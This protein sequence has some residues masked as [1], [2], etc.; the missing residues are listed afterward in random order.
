MKD[1]MVNRGPIAG[2]QG[3]YDKA[4]QEFAEADPMK[5][6]ANSGIPY[7]AGASAFLADSLGERIRITHPDGQVSM[8]GSD[9]KPL[10][11]W[12]FILMHHLVRADGA[13]LGRGMIGYRETSSGA[14]YF[15]SHQDKTIRP[16]ELF[17]ADKPASRI[18]EACKA[19]GA[20]ACA[21]SSADVCATFQFAPR[22]PITFQLW[23]PDEEFGCQ[24]NLLYDASAN[25]YLHTEDIAVASG[26]LSRFLM[27]Q[28]KGMFL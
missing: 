5:Q 3:S 23:L 10:W 7:D 14:F 21:D 8:D 19:L 18:L 20:E 13:T 4:L 22:F 9:A 26:I 11:T 27:A 17:F 24:V 25:H 28:Y 2:Y 1:Y 6:A 16:M 15:P 12:G